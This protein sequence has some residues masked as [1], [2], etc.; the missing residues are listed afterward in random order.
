[1]ELTNTTRVEGGR[2]A[3]K[4]RLGLAAV[5][6]ALSAALVIPR[7]GGTTPSITDRAAQTQGRISVTMSATTL[8]AIAKRR[9]M[10]RAFT[11]LDLPQTSSVC[12]PCIERQHPTH[13]AGGRPA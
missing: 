9:T 7:I 13:L 8:D 6:V 4:T 12:L 1:M 11:R 10:M 3:R 2:R 5:M